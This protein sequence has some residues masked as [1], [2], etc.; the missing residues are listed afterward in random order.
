MSI[1]KDEGNILSDKKIIKEGTVIHV[2]EKKGIFESLTHKVHL[3]LT[4]DKLYLFK[5]AES[6]AKPL[7]E[8]IVNRDSKILDI[9]H[10]KGQQHTFG[11]QHFQ[12]E[13]MFAFPEEM[14]KDDWEQVISALLERHRQGRKR[15]YPEDIIILENGDYK[16][17]LRLITT[18]TLNINAIIISDPNKISNENKYDEELGFVSPRGSKITKFGYPHGSTL[19]GIAVLLGQTQLIKKI[20]EQKKQTPNLSLQDENGDTLLHLCTKMTMNKGELT[21]IVQELIDNKAPCDIL[22]NAG[23]TPLM[24]ACERGLWKMASMLIFEGKANVNLKPGL[25][26]PLHLA[27]QN[28]ELKIIRELLSQDVNLLIVNSNGQTPI[29]L[30]VLTKDKE[31]YM[32]LLQKDSNI[33]AKGK[34]AKNYLPILIEVGNEISGGLEKIKEILTN[35]PSLANFQWDNPEL[36]IEK[37]SLIAAAIEHDRLDVATYLLDSSNFNVNVNIPISKNVKTLNGATEIHTLYPIHMAIMKRNQN[38]VQFLLNKGADTKI[39]TQPEGLSCLMLAIKFKVSQEIIDLLMND[40][41]IQAVSANGE[42]LMHF[43]ADSGN[44]PLIELLI[45]KGLDLH[46][47]TL[48]GNETVLS[49]ACKGGNLEIVKFLVEKK[50]MDIQGSGKEL[51]TTGSYPPLLCAV[52]G[53]SSEVVRYLIDKSKEYDFNGYVNQPKTEHIMKA[54]H[55]ACI[56]GKTDVLKVLLEK[57]ADVNATIVVNGE[58][59]VSPLHLAAGFGWIDIVEILVK[60][61]GMN[62]NLLTAGKQTPLHF[63]MKRLQLDMVKKLLGECGA[64]PDGAAMQLAIQSG[65]VQLLELLDRAKEIAERQSDTPDNNNNDNNNNSTVAPAI[66]SEGISESRGS[67]NGNLA[68]GQQSIDDLIE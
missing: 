51:Y 67:T 59:G 28:R 18:T 68:Q 21:N 22:D 47:Q 52:I 63:A 32:L 42:N 56:H 53:G 20:F 43:A 39:P 3:V 45:S 34:M 66:G 25:T 5:N 8:I 4:K 26:T 54:I 17:I 14:D 41:D 48:T 31:L 61:K 9:E 37:C 49:S 35:D 40:Q 50:L 11:V 16:E 62:P 38:M 46:N 60:E 29:D 13:V 1:K 30:S 10:F 57:D 12:D 55:L 6:L 15:I 24:R 7:H 27:I 36:G 2:R 23:Y 44:L 33:D 64:T 19:L 65:N 58:K